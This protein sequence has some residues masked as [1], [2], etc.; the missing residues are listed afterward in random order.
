[1]TG[2]RADTSD[3]SEIAA[4][5]PRGAECGVCLV[6]RTGDPDT[7]SKLE[8]ALR[9]K[10]GQPDWFSNPTIAKWLQSKGHTTTYKMVANHRNGGCAAK[11]QADE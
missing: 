11:F 5:G 9:V 3:L 8:Q 1:M 6:I 7:V 2:P 10:K 4:F